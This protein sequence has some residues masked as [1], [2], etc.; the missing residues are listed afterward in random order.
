MRSDDDRDDNR[1]LQRGD[2]QS[3]AETGGRALTQPGVAIPPEEDDDEINLAD[4]WLVIRKYKW[5]IISFAALVFTAT[6]IGTALM[7]PVYRAT[8]TL[9]I[10]EEGAQVLE[11]QDLEG[12]P[13]RGG[14]RNFY[15]TQFEILKSRSLA[16]RVIEELGLMDNPELNG[17]IGQRGIMAGIGQVKG[18]VGSLLKGGGEKEPPTEEEKRA[19]VVDRFLGKLSISPV[20]DSKLVDVSFKSFSPELAARV[21]D[22]L[23]QEY[24]DANL[25]RK[26]EAGDEAR[27]FLQRQLADMQAQLERS[28]KKL[29]DFAE[30]Q[31]IADLESRIELTNDKLSQLEETLTEVQ[32]KQ[33]ETRIKYERI[34]NG[35]GDSLPEI[36][37][38]EILNTLQEEL[39]A[40]RSEYSELSGKFKPDY[41]R[42]QELAKRIQELEQQ[43]E[44]EKKEIKQGI[45]SRHLALLEQE[46]SLKES[47]E[48]QEQ[49]L[50]TLNQKK[51][52]YDI[53]KREVESNEELYNGLLSR[54]KE[55]GV[56][57]G[58]EENNIAVIDDARTPQQPAAPNMTLNA[59]LALFLG[60]FGG[61]GIAFLLQ[62]LDNTVRRPEDLEQIAQLPSL[63]LVPQAK[64]GRGRRAKDVDSQ[65]LAL[66][67][68]T[69]PQAEFS[70]SFRSLRTS[71]MFSS[72]EGMPGRLLVASPGPGE[73]KTTSVTN[74]GCVLAQNGERVLMVDADLRKP[75]LHRVFGIGQVPGLTERIARRDLSRMNCVHP[76]NVENLYVLP[77]G[78]IPP[79]PAELLGPERLSGLLDE[80][81]QF[82]DHLILDTAPVLGLA[83]ALVL[84]RSADGVMLVASGGRTTKES[85]R[86]AVGRLR[87][88]RAPLL[89]ATLNNVDLSSPDYSYYT[90]NYYYAYGDSKEGDSGLPVTAAKPAARNSDTDAA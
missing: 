72:P 79:N 68:R 29:Q 25:E 10:K 22:T 70:E 36:V 33:R 24:I 59:S 37:N 27:E 73:G 13:S 82:F 67:S 46:K 31:G 45:I 6:V 21:T 90:S 14:D 4:L 19:K 8:T 23:A 62:F 50:L 53:L 54:M 57:A 69:H 56:A 75:R 39:V 60:V 44:A 15:S 84:S 65:A 64:Q 34:Q 49:R 88:V 32:Q 11:Y 81:G 78:T 87:Q 1:P 28:D 86:Y 17:E 55:I 42:M 12:A 18:L 38:S 89:G 83:D 16:Q 61:T 80:L 74:L 40:L 66:Y 47:L 71:L 41:P 26:Y 77:S 85:L 7:R 51:T 9:Q 2:E 43:I 52:K 35:K 58:A 48:S 3:P 63:G 5:T 76:T 30:D 20:G